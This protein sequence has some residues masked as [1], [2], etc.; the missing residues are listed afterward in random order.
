MYKK[1]FNSIELTYLWYIYTSTY[2]SRRLGVFF[3][4]SLGITEILFPEKDLK[5]IDHTVIVDKSTLQLQKIL[6]DINIDI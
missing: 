3:S 4:K 1:K 2:N 5:T 6:I